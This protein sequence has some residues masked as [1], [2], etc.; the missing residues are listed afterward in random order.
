VR[1][2]KGRLNQTTKREVVESLINRQLIETTLECSEERLKV[3]P[4]AFQLLT[5]RGVGVNE[6]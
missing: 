5:K 3:T 1:H 6:S 2:R 4:H